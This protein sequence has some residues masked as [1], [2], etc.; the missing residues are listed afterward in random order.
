[1]FKQEIEFVEEVIKTERKELDQDI[2]IARCEQI[3]FELAQSVLLDQH[4]TP[5]QRIEAMRQYNV[6]LSQSIE[7]R[8][9]K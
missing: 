3:Q 1:L 4:A 5:D 2:R 6:A 7:M 9:L 8:K